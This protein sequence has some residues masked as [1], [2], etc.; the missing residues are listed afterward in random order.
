MGERTR[1]TF[2]ELLSTGSGKAGVI[3]ISVLF[4]I[5]LGVVITYP[6][7]FGLKY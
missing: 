7:D 5:S 3:F 2:K 1:S 4:I 6:P